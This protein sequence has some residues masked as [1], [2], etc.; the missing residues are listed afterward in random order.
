M[1][2]NEK[3]I[4]EICKLMIDNEN[5]LLTDAEREIIKHIVDRSQNWQELFLTMMM[6]SKS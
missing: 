4:K 5:R 1:E 3:Q 6:A 2:M